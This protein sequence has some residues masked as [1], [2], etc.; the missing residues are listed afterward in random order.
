MFNPPTILSDGF[1]SGSQA[2]I[3]CL[4][5]QLVHVWAR[6]WINERKATSV[7][8]L[9]AQLY[10][11]HLDGPFSLAALP[12]SQ[13]NELLSRSGDRMYSRPN[14]PPPPPPLMHPL[15]EIK[16]PSVIRWETLV[17]WPVSLLPSSDRY[18]FVLENE[19]LSLVLLHLA[20]RGGVSGGVWK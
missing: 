8:P 11:E 4:L 12:Y 16:P 3:S 18:L 17:C 15:G 13:M 10:M 7:L 6:I 1:Q 14:D 5:D 19:C 9:R 20:K 2:S